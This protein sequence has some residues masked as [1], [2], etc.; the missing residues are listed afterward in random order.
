MYLA[1]AGKASALCVETLPEGGTCMD[2][3]LKG[4]VA[5]VT[6]CS[7]GIGREVAKWF[8]AEGV[9][10]VITARR[11]DLLAGLQGE[12]EKAGGPPPLAV[13]ADHRDRNS[14]ARIRDEALKKFGRVDILVN[15][16]G[17]SQPLGTDSPDDVWDGAIEIGFTSIR[18]LTEAFLPGMRER[19]FGRVLNIGG[20]NEPPGINAMSTTKA[21]VQAW[22]KG[23]SRIVGKD[24]I[25]VNCIV[26]GTIH[27]EQIDERLYPT[28]EIQAQFSKQIP[29]GYFG[30]PGD[31]AFLILCLCSPKAR[32]ITGQ[33]IFVDGGTRRS[34]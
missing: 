25:T 16:A 7:V 8:A 14:T 28:P 32:Y 29:V 19:K 21:A 26:P 3:E 33:R 34:I 1:E 30:D 10:T 5:V 11:A 27:S 4:R 20:S 31:M 18:K 17:G 13:T 23:L 15:N 22:S 6:G 24:G 9:Q 2:L 12:I